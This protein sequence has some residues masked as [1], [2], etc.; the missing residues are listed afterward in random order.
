V[1]QLSES[2]AGYE[3]S[4]EKALAAGNAKKAQEA[5]E[6]AEARKVWLLEAEKSLA[7]FK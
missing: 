2:I 4:A 6:S 3:K 7:E 5:K 1:K